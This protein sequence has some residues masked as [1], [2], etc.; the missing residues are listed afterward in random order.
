MDVKNN[1]GFILAGLFVVCVVGIFLP[2]LSASTSYASADVNFFVETVGKISLG[3]AVCGAALS[4]VSSQKGNKGMDKL[5]LVCAI[6]ILILCGI[7]AY[8]NMNKANSSLYKGLNVH[9]GI[10]FY[11]II[12]SMI[13]A[14]V[15]SLLGKKNDNS[16]PVMTG[17]V[18]Q[19]MGP[20]PMGA[21][22]MNQP[23]NQP[24]GVPVQP[25]VQPQMG[26]PP[27]SQPM[28]NPGV[29]QP[30]GQP[31]QQPVNNSIP[32]QPMNNGMAQPTQQPMNN[33]T[34]NNYN[35]NNFQ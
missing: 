19:P 34:F 12:G 33:Q 22:M 8:A 15:V 4:I 31:V 29:Q 14:V 10:G 1:N 13:V 17:P 24:M 3:L 25:Q 21:P 7:S 11:I 27:V 23:V 26:Q 6:L 18:G 30:M 5:P 32:Q 9:F 28:N 35:N 20:R 16:A 2:F